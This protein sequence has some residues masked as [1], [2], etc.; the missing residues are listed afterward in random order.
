MADGEGRGEEGERR[1]KKEEGRRGKGEEKR[2][3]IREQDVERRE[4]SKRKKKEEAKESKEKRSRVPS[5]LPFCRGLSAETRLTVYR[6]FAI[7]KLCELV[8]VFRAKRLSIIRG[9]K[10]QSSVSNTYRCHT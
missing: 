1:R 6:R 10:N 7:R 9:S 4:D 8:L 2:E 5:A 3:T